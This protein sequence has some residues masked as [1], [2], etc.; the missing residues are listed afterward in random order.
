MREIWEVLEN[1]RESERMTER[2]GKYGS[3]FVF[4][5]FV[6][7]PFTS[8]VFIF[9]KRGCH[10]AP[11]YWCWILNMEGSGAGSPIVTTVGMRMITIW[12]WSWGPE[13]LNREIWSRLSDLHQIVRNPNF[14]FVLFF[15]S[16]FGLSSL[17][18]LDSQK[19]PLYF[20]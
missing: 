1:E 4:F 7:I 19:G 2:W 18:F 12:F 15:S 16:F 17:E 9:L 3:D 11:I 5:L 8:F 20:Y 13:S 6:F 14:L 10:V